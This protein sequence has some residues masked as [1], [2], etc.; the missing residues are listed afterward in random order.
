MLYPN[1]K[2]LIFCKAPII[3]QVKTRLT[4]VI[5]PKQAVAV[6][7]QLTHQTLK[8]VTAE[9]LCPVQLWCS[10]ETSHPFFKE[11]A[12]QYSLSLHQQQRGDL[13]EKMH[14]AFESALQQSQ[15]VLLIG[16]D[17]PSLQMDDL[18]EALEALTQKN[19]VVL[20]PAEDG[21]YTLIGLKH[22]QPELFKAINWGTNRVLTTTLTRISEQNLVLHLLAEQWDV[23]YPEDLTRY[24][25]GYKNG[26]LT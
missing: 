15:A 23:D 2:L 26:L 4:S 1:A 17:C 3:G 5:T 24:Q 21:G 6:H 18:K 8:L 12:S 11:C 9:H 20:A 25:K 14:H 7:Q 19:D 10:P 16:C 22:P 13:G